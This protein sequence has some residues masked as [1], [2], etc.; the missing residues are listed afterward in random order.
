MSKVQSVCRFDAARESFNH[1]NMFSRHLAPVLR[2]AAGSLPVVTLVG[3]RQS[4]KTL[5]SNPTSGGLLVHG[6]DR[7]FSHGDVTVRPWFL[8]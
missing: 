4:G 1:S 8:A 7:A 6:G 5:P 2:A 3:P